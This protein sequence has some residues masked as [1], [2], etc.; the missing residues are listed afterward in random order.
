VEI[1][2]DDLLD[3]KIPIISESVTDSNMSY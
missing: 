3:I 1:K 2:L